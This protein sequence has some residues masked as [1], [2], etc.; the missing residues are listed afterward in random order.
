MQAQSGR[1]IQPSRPRGQR[2]EMIGERDGIRTHAFLIKRPLFAVILL[3]N[4]PD[5]AKICH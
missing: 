2:L 1:G 4:F 3:M 5:Q